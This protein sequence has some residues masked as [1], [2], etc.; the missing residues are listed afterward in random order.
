MANQGE[1][2]GERSED[3]FI[4]LRTNTK[5]NTTGQEDNLMKSYYEEVE[6]ITQLSEEKIDEIRW[7]NGIEIQGENCPK[8][9]TSFQDL[10]LP[11]ELQEYLQDNGYI[12]PTAIQMQALSCVMSGRDIIGLAETGSGKTLA[13]SLPLC[14]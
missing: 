3:D 10:K 4:P 13:Y 8:P 5:R 14:M 2:K 12:S 7:Q 9:I 11:P 6:N 1:G